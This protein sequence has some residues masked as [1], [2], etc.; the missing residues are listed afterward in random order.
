MNTV[1]NQYIESHSETKPNRD[2]CA[3]GLDDILHANWPSMSPSTYNTGY[4][5]CCRWDS[6]CWADV[7]RVLC[8]WWH[9]TYRL[10]SGWHC[11][12]RTSESFLP[13]LY[14]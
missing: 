5:R 4:K 8:T 7:I 3:R 11:L 10:T 1:H 12:A 14:S 2:E 13:D 6:T 9:T